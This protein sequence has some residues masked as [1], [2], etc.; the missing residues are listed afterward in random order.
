MLYRLPKSD[1]VSE[2][3]ENLDIDFEI[4]EEDM[5]DLIKLKENTQAMS[6]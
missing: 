4:S 3:K 1:N 2:M 6:V 5:A